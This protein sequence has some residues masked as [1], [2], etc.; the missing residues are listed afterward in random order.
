MD[1]YYLIT[2]KKILSKCLIYV[3][4]FPLVWYHHIVSKYETG[5]T[6]ME[7]SIIFD[8]DWWDP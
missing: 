8:K 1:Y 5:N 3:Q 2:F 7:V 6:E 4:V